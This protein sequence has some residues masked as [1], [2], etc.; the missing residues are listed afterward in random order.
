M[1]EDWLHKLK[2]RM[3]DFEIDEPAGLWDA[4]ENAGR[5]AR[6]EDGNLSSHNFTTKWARRLTVAA[7]LIAAVA[8][9]G[10]YIEKDNPEIARAPLW[11]TSDLTSPAE[12]HES[13]M[14]AGAT[15]PPAGS[16]HEKATSVK[17]VSSDSTLQNETAGTDGTLPSDSSVKSGSRDT[18]SDSGKS[19]R[20]TD[21]GNDSVKLQ[22]GRRSYVFRKNSSATQSRLTASASPSGNR[23]GN[24]FTIS[25]YGSGQVGAKL[26]SSNDF[27][28]AAFP[29]DPDFPD[30]KPEKPAEQEVKLPEDL[31]HRLPVRIVAGF[32]Y[33]ITDRI[34][35][36][37]GLSYAKLVSE[38]EEG[39][40]VNHVIGKQKLHYLG[41]PL[42]I[43]YR[44]YSWKIIDFYV[45]G[46]G[47]WEKCVSAKLHKDYPYNKNKAYEI[48]NIGKKPMQWSVN[49]AA[50][51]QC[52]LIS[53]PNSGF[54]SMS[55]FVEPGV[56]YYFNDGSPINT[57]YKDKP[58]N[59]NL[60]LGIRLSFGR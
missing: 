24:S 35:I 2:D 51:I 57:I 33:N 34:G 7:A 41:I 15:S 49:A 58:F 59:F 40:N 29:M 19:L 55:V 17:E 8:F 47:M 25:L 21:S 1:K 13:D 28:D 9:L 16:S 27:C 26:N 39:S 48:L 37:T 10:I 18:E 53:R 32:T 14:T 54:H 31:H 22:N 56:S 30:I 43:K 36:E 3:S 12:S 5:K 42:N 44:I 46:G 11:P 4:I 38:F 23:R 20:K 60:N 50:G 6:E 52:N 45:S